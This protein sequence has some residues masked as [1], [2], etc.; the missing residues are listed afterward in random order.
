M[1]AGY[2]YA[3][4]SLTRRPWIDF[5]LS[6]TVVGRHLEVRADLL[7]HDRS[8]LESDETTFFYNIFVLHPCSV[9]KDPGVCVTGTCQFN[10]TSVKNDLGIAEGDA[11]E[12][13]KTRVSAN[14]TISS[15]SLSS[16]IFRS[17]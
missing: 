17:T 4:F 2:C 6:S 12:A 9:M 7:D 16:S 11:F 13:P 5:L 1:K 14:V 3:N 8:S 10:K 15:A